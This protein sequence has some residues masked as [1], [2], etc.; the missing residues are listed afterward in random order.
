MENVSGPIRLTTGHFSTEA[1][2]DHLN[3]DN[4]TGPVSYSGGVGPSSPSVNSGWS[5]TWSSDS[6]IRKDGWRMCLSPPCDP[7]SY[8]NFATANISICP[9]GFACSGDSSKF[10]CGEWKFAPIGSTHCT[11][12]DLPKIVN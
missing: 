11:K 6:S 9:A 3:M 8:F 2:C 1:C 10:H 12:C 5:F 7:G 4:G